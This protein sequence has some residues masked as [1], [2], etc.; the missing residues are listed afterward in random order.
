MGFRSAL[1]QARAALTQLLQ[2]REPA[3]GQG[4]IRDPAATKHTTAS[5]AH[6]ACPLLWARWNWRAPGIRPHCH[7]GQF[8][9]IANSTSKTATDRPECAACK[10]RCGGR[11]GSLRSPRCTDDRSGRFGSDDQVGSAHGGGHGRRHR[12]KR[13]GRNPQE[14]SPGSAHHRWRPGSDSICATGLPVVN[15]R[16][17]DAKTRPT[18]SRSTHLRPSSVACSPNHMGQGRLRHWQLEFDHLHGSHRDWRRVRQVYRGVWNRGWS[19]AEKK[20]LMG[21]GAEWIG[22]LPDVH[23]PGAVQIVDFY[24]GPQHLWNLART[25]TPMIH[26]PARLDESSS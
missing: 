3:A 18:A 10:V 17:T 6:D 5:G 9:V 8:P 21:D 4:A 25:Y 23:F 12:Q 11:G 7:N 24:H 1:H 15:K 19:R 13:R 16:R 26:E 20:V 14:R 2:F 22:N